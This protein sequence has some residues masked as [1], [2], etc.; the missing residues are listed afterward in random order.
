MADQ[1]QTGP[2]SEQDELFDVRLLDQGW[3]LLVPFDRAR[4]VFTTHKI[5]RDRERFAAI[6]QAIGEGQSFSAIAR[7]F[8]V[9]RHTLA[10][11]VAIHPEVVAQ[12]RKRGAGR[13]AVLARLAAD[14]MID[15]IGSMPLQ[16]LPIVLGVA[17][18]KSLLLDGLATS[19]TESKRTA[20]T[21]D[22]INAWVARLGSANPGPDLPSSAQALNPQQSVSTPLPGADQGAIIASQEA[23]QPPDRPTAA[24]VPEGGGGG[25]P[26]AGAGAQLDGSAHGNS[27]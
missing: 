14:R 7:A 4:H 15:E 21:A 3:E 6:L 9:S 23:D 27:G 25:S 24:A 8:R 20:P 22:E 26:A 2:I 5:Q 10:A 18:E 11:I 12:E 16:S 17:T 19:I 1:F 13:F